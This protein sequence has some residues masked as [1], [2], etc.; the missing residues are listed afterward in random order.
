MSWKKFRTKP[1][2][3]CQGTFLDPN[4]MRISKIA[5]DFSYLEPFSQYGSF[6]ELRWFLKKRKDSK[7][8]SSN[9]RILTFLIANF[10]AKPCSGKFYRDWRTNLARKNDLWGAKISN[11]QDFLSFLMIFL[12]KFC[13]SP[14]DD[15]TFEEIGA[16]W[17]NGTKNVTISLKLSLRCRKPHFHIFFWSEEVRGQT[18]FWDEKSLFY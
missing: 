14:S 2:G 10:W 9:F 4:F 1:V 15:D 8:F 16:W 12:P 11:F 18:H 5:S 7:W 6:S 3:T 13:Q 17:R